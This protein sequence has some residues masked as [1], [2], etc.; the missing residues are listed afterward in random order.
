MRNAKVDWEMIIFGNAVHGFTN[1]DNGSDPS[2]GNAY[3]K[4][5]D[6]RSWEAMREFFRE[7]F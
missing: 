7:I 5:A 3:N 4:T 1:P 6:M 2:K